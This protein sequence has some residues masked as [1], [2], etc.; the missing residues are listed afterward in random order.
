MATP[1]AEVDLVALVG[2]AGASGSAGAG[3]SELV[4]VEVKTG[5]LGLGAA[6]F[7][8]GRDAG[9]WRPGHRF[10]AEDLARCRRA[11]A[12]IAARA[13]GRAW[14]VDLLEVVLLEDR[15][16]R[17]VHH[18]DLTAPLPRPHREHDSATTC[19]LLP[20]PDPGRDPSLPPAAGRAPLP[21][22]T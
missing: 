11:A 18:P 8:A 1:E 7:D 2:A 6:A 3:P 12:R 5:R 20:D 17:L 15:T 19:V 14:R 13:G 16:L 4:V 21:T 9:R 22:W 10:G